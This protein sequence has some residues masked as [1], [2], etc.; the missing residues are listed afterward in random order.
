[1]RLRKY[2]K[3]RRGGGRYEYW[4]LV[5]SY[6]TV[7][8]PRERIVAYLGD[9]AADLRR[10]VQAAAQPPPQAQPL[11]LFEAPPPPQWV[12]VDVNG[13][14]LERCRRF[15]GPWLGLQ[16]LQQLGLPDFLAQVMPTGRETIPWALMAQVLVLCRL[17]APSSELH[18]AEHYYADSALPDLLGIPVEAVQ[19]DRLYRALD[20][21]LPH[22]EALERHLKDRLGTL[23]AI[24][25]DLLLYDVT[26]TYFEGEAAGNDQARRGY[27][28]DHRSDC[29]QVCIGLV[30]TRQGLPL[31]YEVFAGN[32]TDVTTLEPIVTHMEQRYG[33]AQRIWVL[34]RGMISEDNLAFLQ[35]AGRRY[36]V[37]TPKSLLRRFEPQ[38]LEGPW[39]ALRPGLEVQR[40]ASPDGQ[41]TFILCRSQQRRDKEEA[42]HRRAEERLE[43]HLQ[44]IEVS[45]QRRP[46]TVAQVATR[47][48]RVLGRES[49]ATGL[50]HIEVVADAAG[51]ASVRWTKK[52]S[53][54]QWAQLSEGCYVLRS[55]IADWTAPELWHAYV[56]LTEAEAAFR[57]HKSD[58][59]LRPVWHQRTDRVEAHLLVCFLAYV[60]WKTLG[61][62]CRRAGLGDEP[63][64]VL[65][66]IEGI[67][68]VDVVLPTRQ[69]VEIR[70][71]RLTTPTP[72]QRILL[73]RLAMAL[74]AALTAA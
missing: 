41:E 56:Q 62:M 6:R 60:L 47:V 39:E 25:Y 74:P 48:G 13:V 64:Q 69:G 58:L 54:R 15:G 7:R 2:S 24:D 52:E 65:E 36:I 26:S 19:D 49:R 55:N 46:H 16:V 27:S 35:Q 44:Q 66:E 72:H 17:C 42:M 1:M 31:A 45:C 43:A 37:G 29:K 20:A 51:V 3:A 10:G 12:E 28:R 8:G 63:R 21:L 14:R 33:V 32:R 73:Q 18:I 40:C 57:V 59:K 70:R 61:Q 9:L 11:S 34:D 30:V 38:L 4:A 22:K 50:F 71:R 68:L 23:F 67:R 53:W 5:E